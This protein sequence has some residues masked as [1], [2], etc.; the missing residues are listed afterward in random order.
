MDVPHRGI[1]LAF[2]R[3]YNSFSRHDFAGYDGANE[4][5]QYGNGWTNTWDAHIS[6]NG[7]PN[8]GYSWA[9]FYGFTVHDVDGGRYDYCFNSAGQLVPPTGM[10]GTSLVANPDGGSFYWTKKNGTQ[11]TFYAPYYGGTSAAYSGRIYRISQP[12]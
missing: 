5:G 8:T 7:C 9:G 4:V 2:R 11:Y 3:T 6:T 1:D 12:E 10:Q